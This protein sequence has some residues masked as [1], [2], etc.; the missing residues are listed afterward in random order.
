MFKNDKNITISFIKQPNRVI[1]M[2]GSNPSSL[3]TITLPPSLVDVLSDLQE[4]GLFFSHYNSSAFFPLVFNDSRH[5]STD[6]GG[7]GNET[8]D[9]ACVSSVISATVSRTSL[10]NLQDNVTFGIDITDLVCLY[11]CIHANFH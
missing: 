2:N 6:C 10:S 1:G 11:T 3:S 4:V 9:A 5:V 7:T 8:T